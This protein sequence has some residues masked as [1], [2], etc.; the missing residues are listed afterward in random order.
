LVL[1]QLG[2]I[3]RR[4]H[5]TRARVGD[6]VL[7]LV[8]RQHAAQRIHHGTRLG[9][10]VV[11]DEP[12]PAVRTEETHPV[13]GLYA[14]RDQAVCHTVRQRVELA[15]APALA[16]NDECDAVPVSAGRLWKDVGYR[17]DQVDPSLNRPPNA[18]VQR[19]HAAAWMRGACA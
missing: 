12:F 1:E 15:K 10:A 8:G 3:R 13:A 4:D 9:N 14:A 11:R 18:A 6:R 19:P 5:R 2:L 7:D 17:R 16:V